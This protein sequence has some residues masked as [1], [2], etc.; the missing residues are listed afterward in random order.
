MTTVDTR[1]RADRIRKV[2]ALLRD[3][4]GQWDQRN[5]GYRTACGTTFCFAGWTALLYAPDQVRWVADRNADDSSAAWYLTG[6]PHPEQLAQ[7]ALGLSGTE[8]YWI[9]MFTHPD[10]NELRPVELDELEAKITE[11]TGVTFDDL[12]PAPNLPPAAVSLL[13]Y[14]TPAGV[15]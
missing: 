8:A 4:R 13:T 15:D 2:V 14:R 12:P 6:N 1:I 3:R 9:F 5:W 10:G 11:V 7:E